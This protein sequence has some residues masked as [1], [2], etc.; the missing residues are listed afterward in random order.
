MADQIAQAKQQLSVALTSMGPDQMNALLNSPA[1]KKYKP[2]I[3]KRRDSLDNELGLGDSPGIQEETFDGVS[4]VALWIA[5]MFSVLPTDV[6]GPMSMSEDFFKK[7]MDS[8]R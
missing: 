5:F 8:G 1:S 7:F 4:L 6:S 3:L 2:C